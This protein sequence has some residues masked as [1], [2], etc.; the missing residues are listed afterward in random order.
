MQM[1]S[2]GPT[3]MWCER[4]IVDR[5]VVKA[6]KVC[7]GELADIKM[8]ELRDHCASC[9]LPVIGCVRIAYQPHV[10]LHQRCIVESCDDSLLHNQQ[11]A[12]KTARERLQMQNQFPPCEWAQ[13]GA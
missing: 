9:W 3:C 12:A 4:E 1:L 5:W 11:E 2:T 13:K 6:K 10:T 7:R 8:M